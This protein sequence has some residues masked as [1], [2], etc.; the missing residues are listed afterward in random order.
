M[1]F[2]NPMPMLDQTGNMDSVDLT[3]TE[4]GAEE[5]NLN[6]QEQL[7]SQVESKLNLRSVLHGTFYTVLI[8][9]M[10]MMFLQVEFHIL[11]NDRINGL[12][13][14]AVV[15]GIASTVISSQMDNRVYDPNYVP[16][17]YWRFAIFIFFII[18][19]FFLL[20]LVPDLN[21]I[22][23]IWELAALA[24]TVGAVNLA[25]LWQFVEEEFDDYMEPPGDQG[26][27]VSN[28]AVMVLVSVVL[29][30]VR[31]N[32]PTIQ[33][34]INGL[35]LF[36]FLFYSGFFW[37]YVVYDRASINQL[38]RS[39]LSFLISIMLLPLAALLLDRLGLQLTP[40]VIIILNFVLCTL[41][42][43]AYNARPRLKRWLYAG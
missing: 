26:T 5:R 36:L 23:S 31:E 21:N 17:P 42:F 29:F 9:V 1:Q 30:I 4:F 41:G 27:V 18:G 43:L 38:S 40:T 13:A 33:P 19:E 34:I 22:L 11:D 16:S 37:T 15:L 35:S 8:F 39:A 24:G 32:L 12:I 3:D 2:D 6:L 10:F 7:R 28:Y 20:F 25:V 14:L